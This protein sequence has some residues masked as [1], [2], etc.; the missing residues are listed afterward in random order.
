MLLRRLKRALEGSALATSKRQKRD[1]RRSQIDSVASRVLVAEKFNS[2]EHCHDV[3][4]K[5]HISLVDDQPSPGAHGPRLPSLTSAI[6]RSRVSDNEVHRS[7]LATSTV[8]S[9]PQITEAESGTRGGTLPAG[10]AHGNLQMAVH[11]TARTEFSGN[12]NREAGIAAQS[13]RNPILKIHPHPYDKAPADDSRSLAIVHASLPSFAASPFTPNAYIT[14]PS[15][16]PTPVHTRN[17]HQN[18]QHAATEMTAVRKGGN[19]VSYALKTHARVISGFDPIATSTQ[20]LE[21]HQSKPTKSK[22]AAH[23]NTVQSARGSER[24]Q[25]MKSAPNPVQ[26]TETILDK[27]HAAPGSALE[28]RKTLTAGPSN[29]SAVESSK[30]TRKS[31]LPQKKSTILKGKKAEKARVTP[32]QYAQTLCDKIENLTKKSDYLKDKRIFYAGGD[33]HYA[34]DVTMK[35]MSLVRFWH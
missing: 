14:T 34:S 25:V 29:V 10:L 18:K 7:I 21:K 20:R 24:D 11:S 12:P 5:P 19:F 22:V 9:S 8:I 32:L 17:A 13:S 3:G 31:T 16:E 27:F 30:A 28:A 6:S 23:S 33:M 2:I 26:H 4:D 1:E 35:K 15:E